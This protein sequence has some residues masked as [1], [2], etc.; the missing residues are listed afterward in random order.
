MA[1]VSPY[2]PFPA[3]NG[4]STPQML[5]QPNQPRP[6]YFLSRNNGLL[7]PLVPADELPFNVRLQGVPRVMQIDK[8]YGMQHVGTATYTGMTF[9]LECDIA[10][11]RSNSQPPAATHVR[12][13]SSTPVNPFKQ[14]LAPEALARQA[15]AQSANNQAAAAISAPATTHHPVSAHETSSNWRT[16]T[17]LPASNPTSDKTQHLIDSILASTSGAAE[18]ARIGYTPSPT[19][20]PPSGAQADQD[21]KEYCTYWIR[22]GECDYT[23]QGCLY[24]HEM[25]DKATLEKIG[26][27]TM[28]RWWAEKQAAVKIGGVGGGE[29]MVVGPLVKSEVW[30]KRKPKLKSEKEDGEESDSEASESEAGSVKSAASS[31]KSVAVAKKPA[32]PEPVKTMK[33]TE[34]NKQAK[35]EEADKPAK[36]KAPAT[37]PSPI[38]I[39]K[40]S[41][42]SDLI[43]F[44]IPLLPTPSPSTP[45]LTPTS[46]VDSSPRTPYNTPPT[47]PTPTV[48]SEAVLAKPLTTATKV[49]VPKGESAERHIADAKK[50]AARQH[51][52]RG[53]SVSTIDQSKVQPLEKQIQEMQ[54]AKNQ[55]Q[56]LAASKYATPAAASKARQP[57]MRSGKT[58]G[59]RVRRPATSAAAPMKILKKEGAGCEKKA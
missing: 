30:L 7:V 50:R 55:P 26:F 21:K 20:T 58:G 54:K 43:D 5:P 33:V 57:A 42:T 48:A 17:T 28:P 52:R 3:F 56:G 10:M 34:I 44:A 36:A 9:K 2:S 15:L 35:A 8:T 14:Y 49:F 25:P 37:I 46:S 29:K 22:T 38:D 4:R 24:K 45:C 16:N 40:A 19:T 6:L 1:S 11:Q 47:P 59:C 31:K 27:R 32:T 12:S 18:A 53:A 13:Q 23:Q 51:A 41:T 39:R